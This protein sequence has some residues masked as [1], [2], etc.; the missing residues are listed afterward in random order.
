MCMGRSLLIFSNV[1]LKWPAWR[2]YWIFR[3]LDSVGGMVSRAKLKFALEFQLQISNAY[4]LRLWA[5]ACSLSVT[6][7]SN[8]PPG[9]HIVFFG[10][11][12]LPIFWFW[13]ARFKLHWYI[14]CV[15]GKKPIDFLQCHLKMAAWRPYWIFRCLDSVGGMV[16]RAL[17]T[18][19]LEFQFQISYA[20]SLCPWAK[21][22]LIFTDVTLAAWRDFWTLTWFWLW[23][24]SPNLSSALLMYMERNLL[25][26]RVVIFKMAAG[27]P[28]W[29][30]QFPDS[31]FS[32]AL[33]IKS[34][35]H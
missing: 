19:A 20:C 11:R 14:T 9:S 22:L 5:E 10:F 1:T 6:S 12:T 16:S 21:A 34:K 28:Y 33:S 27:R 13:I 4:C 2:P 18:F 35:L 32:L 29:I 23:I 26:F 31:K 15:Y 25:I 8:W 3:F 17:L 24:W 7:L 30:F